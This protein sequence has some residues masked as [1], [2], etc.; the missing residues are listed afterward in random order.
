MEDLA[1]LG[2]TVSGI[3]LVGVVTVSAG[4]EGFLLNA[5]VCLLAPTKTICNKLCTRL[6]FYCL[7]I[8]GH[9][10]PKI[11]EDSIG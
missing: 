2:P 11:V 3:L 1:A 7:T 4:F 8:F 10:S 6:S 9:L 5:D